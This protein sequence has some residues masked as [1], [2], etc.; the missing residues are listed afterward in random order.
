M[1]IIQNFDKLATSV[2]RRQTLLIAEAGYE[3]INTKKAVEN[4]VSFNAKKIC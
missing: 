1:R 3:A 2:L 4:A